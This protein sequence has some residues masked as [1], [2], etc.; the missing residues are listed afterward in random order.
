MKSSDMKY[1][2]TVISSLLIC[3]KNRG[4]ITSMVNVNLL[5]EYI[6][7]IEIEIWMQ[8]HHK[9]KTIDTHKNTNQIIGEEILRFESSNRILLFRNS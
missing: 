2:V 1:I 8:R 7:N 9:H 4:H 5:N 3:D 6:G